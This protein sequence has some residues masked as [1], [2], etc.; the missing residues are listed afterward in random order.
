MRK[1]LTKVLIVTNSEVDAIIT[2]A[3]L[4]ANTKAKDIC[5]KS[6][7]FDEPVTEKFDSAV[8][9]K[10]KLDVLS[11]D[12]IN[13]RIEFVNN[14]VIPKCKNVFDHNSFNGVIEPIKKYTYGEIKCTNN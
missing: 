11:Q 14:Q 1:K 13:K 4:L 12:E 5:F 6:T 2:S 8:I 3:I 7:S 10:Y 9:L